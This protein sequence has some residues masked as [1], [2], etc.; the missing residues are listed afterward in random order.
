MHSR[1]VYDLHELGQLGKIS[2]DREEFAARI[3][4]LHEKLKVRIKHSNASYDIK[5]DLRRRRKNMKQ[6]TWFWII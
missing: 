6:E 4:E 2:V 1:G 5:A 3:N